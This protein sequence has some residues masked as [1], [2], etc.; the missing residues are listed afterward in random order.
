M[1]RTATRGICAFCHGEFAKSGMTRHLTT[2]SRRP[3]P[4]LTVAGQE[5]LLHLL[6][7]GDGL[8]EYWMHIEVPASGSLGELD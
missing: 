8:P 1:A 7:E 6:V 5:R 3:L 2:C 4:D